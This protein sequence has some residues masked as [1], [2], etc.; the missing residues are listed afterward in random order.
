[1][2]ITFV[3]TPAVAMT[4]GSLEGL[5]D[6]VVGLAARCRRRHIW[7]LALHRVY[8]ISRRQ[9]NRL[10]MIAAGVI[11]AQVVATAVGVTFGE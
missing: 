4:F 8:V 3:F 10:G 1:M 6:L 11:H 9:D 2:G 7:K 5:P